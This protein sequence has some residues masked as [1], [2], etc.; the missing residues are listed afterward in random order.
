MNP[1]HG[2]LG[3][4]APAS[5]SPAYQRIVQ[6]ELASARLLMEDVLESTRVALKQREKDARTGGELL[7]FIKAGE[8]LGKLGSVIAERYPGALGKA[9]DRVALQRQNP[10]EKSLFNVRFDDL[11][12]MDEAQVIESVEAATAM[13]VLS[14]SIER[15]LSEFEELICAAQGQKTVSADYNPLRPQVYLEAL[16]EVLRQMQLTDQVRNEWV[17]PMAQVLASKLGERYTTHAQTMRQMGVTPAGRLPQ[18]LSGDYAYRAQHPSAS[19]SVGFDNHTEAP[20]AS[21]LP[22]DPLLTLGRLHQLLL[23]DQRTPLEHPHIQPTPQPPAGIEPITLGVHDQVITPADSAPPQRPAPHPQQS[24]DTQG[25][26]APPAETA[27]TLHALSLEVVT[28]LVDNIVGDNRLLLPV[29]QFINS[30]KPA[31]LQMVKADPRFFS[32]KEHPAHLLLREITDRSL[33]FDRIQAAGF[34]SFMQSLIKIA[35]PLATMKIEGPEPFDNVLQ[36]LYAQWNLQQE[37]L[38]GQRL[39][40]IDALQHA[41][42]RHLLAAKLARDLWLL[43]AIDKVP[44]EVSRFVLGPWTQVMAEARLKDTSGSAD[45]G[46]YREAVNALFW[47]AQP[48]I[49]RHHTDR[50]IRLLPKLLAKL[51]EGL[52]MID[53]PASRTE[54]FFERLMQL[55]QEAFKPARAPRPAKSAASSPPSSK[56]PFTEDEP[57]LAPAEAKDSGFMPSTQMAPGDA[58]A[59]P[60]HHGMDGAPDS[61]ESAAAA[62][63]ALA[64]GTWVN[65]RVNGEWERTQLT[66]IGPHDKLF[67]FTSLTGRTQSMTLRLLERLMAQGDIAVIT[68]R[69]VIDGALDAVARTAMRN[70]VDGGHRN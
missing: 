8:A 43:P 9:I 15:P 21:A 10:T 67:L 68:D 27:G 70:S 23:N 32:D 44:S 55:H 69:T 7:A 12:L 40:A 30:L 60:S 54:A 22:P 52:A 64:V 42:Q 26:A 1:H 6:D 37:S 51:R 65:L 17:V 34:T 2:G 59:Q 33:A 45:P 66:W 4:G 53:Y 14:A 25:R 57:W 16:H 28:M 50:L 46:R 5:A 41:E 19:Q 61:T 38:K 3:A 47:S 11:E 29:Q 36:Q 31:L 63:P 24:G 39:R 56:A 18:P 13:E 62:L 58:T 20:V 35:G 49:T 48:D